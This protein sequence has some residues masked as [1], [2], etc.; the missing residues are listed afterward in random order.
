MGII[1]ARYKGNYRVE[2]T[3]KDGK[4]GIADLSE[5]KDRGGVFES[6]KEE[7]FFRQFE[8]D[9]DFGILK[10][11]GGI[12]IAPETLYAKAMSYGG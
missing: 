7:G 3:F 8:V 9:K 11:P 2:L 1:T 5:Y 10:W 12:D 4:C 6:F